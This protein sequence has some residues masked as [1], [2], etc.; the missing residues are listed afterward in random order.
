MRKARVNM[1]GNVNTMII[2]NKR[3]ISVSGVFYRSYLS[4]VLV[5]IADRRAKVKYSP[6]HTWRARDDSPGNQHHHRPTSRPNKIPMTLFGRLNE[7]PSLGGL[8]VIISCQRIV[9]IHTFSQELSLHLAKVSRMHV[10]WA[11]SATRKKNK[12]NIGDGGAL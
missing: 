10:P 9:P 12:K 5:A 7:S 6:V 11:C 4:D 3:I 8:Q 2:L 1:I